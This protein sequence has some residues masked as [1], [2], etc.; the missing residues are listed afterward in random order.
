MKNKY[1][2][3]LVMLVCIALAGFGLTGAYVQHENKTQT[4]QEMTVVT[5]F[6]PVYIAAA[7]VIGDTDTVTLKNLSEPQTGCLHDYQ[8]TPEDMKLLSSADVF[9]VN[10]GGIET[11]LT[12]VAKTYPDLDIIYSAE[13]VPML[14]D[15]AHVWMNTHNYE[16]QVQTIAA[17]LSQADPENKETYENNAQEYC[18]KIEQL[19]SRIRALRD[20]LE[21]EPVV[22]F[23]EAYEYVAEEYGLNVVGTIDL[24]EERQV[25]AG[26][27]ADILAAID[28]YDVPVVLAEQLYGESMGKTVEKESDAQVVYLDPLTRGDYDRDSYLNTMEH[29]IDLLEQAYSEHLGREHSHAH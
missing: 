23:H 9:I 13:D 4:Q 25:S 17:Q 21:G 22:I 11:F 8:L 3:V 27:V 26:E 24:D 10:G 6:Y 1:I 2:F 12:D 29:N 7:N 15:N 5:S 14:G 28:E 18:R 19:G 20:Q 16:T